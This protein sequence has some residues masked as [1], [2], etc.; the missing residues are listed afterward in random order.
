VVRPSRSHQ[1]K[2]DGVDFAFAG[3]RHALGP[4]GESDASAAWQKRILFESAVTH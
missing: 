4:R 2:L 3:I 1:L